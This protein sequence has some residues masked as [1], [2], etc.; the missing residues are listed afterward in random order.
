MMSVS[1]LG[2]MLTDTKEVNGWVDA[3][4]DFC[5]GL[6]HVPFRCFWTTVS[7]TGCNKSSSSFSAH[8]RPAPHEKN[9]QHNVLLAPP[10]TK[11]EMK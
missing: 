2:E 3:G 8:S 10:S 11:K 9:K 6:T 1:I 4:A 7:Q 5:D